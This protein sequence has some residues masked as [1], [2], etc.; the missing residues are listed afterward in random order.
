MVDQALP[1]VQID[2]ANKV[3]RKTVRQSAQAGISAELV[4]FLEVNFIVVYYL[5]VMLGVFWLFLDT[6]SNRFSV[7]YWLGIR[8][9]ILADSTVPAMVFAIAG[10]ILGSVLYNIRTLF[11]YYLKKKEFNYRWLAIYISAPWESAVMALLVFAL[12]QGGLALLG[13]LPATDNT[14]TSRFA[15]F[16]IGALVGFGMRNVVDWMEELTGTMFGKKGTST[17]NQTSTRSEKT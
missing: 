17:N 14:S 1:A 3:E 2:A 8:E 7:M 6:W 10:G 4:N 9:Q 13:G 15:S 16:G 12:I 5:G 11:H